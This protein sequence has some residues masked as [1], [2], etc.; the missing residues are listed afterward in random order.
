VDGATLAVARDR[1]AWRGKLAA[2]VTLAAPVRGCNAGSLIDWAW[3]VTAEPDALG[4]AGRDLGERWTDAAEQQRLQR[5]AAF[6]RAAGARLLTLADP[7]DAVVRPDE[8][9][10]PAPGE[11]TTD[12]IVTSRVMRPGSLGHGAML[13]DPAVW[14]RVL[15]VVGAQFV[16][17]PGT[18]A[19]DPIET[20]LQALKAKLRAQGRIG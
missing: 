1:A 20:E 11:S 6:L 4:Q 12:L 16:G 14:R 15:S 17:P 7:E 18:A 9:L 10:L 19:P 3:L 8:A 5:R 13:D 2:I